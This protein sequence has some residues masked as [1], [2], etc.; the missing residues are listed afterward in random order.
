VNHLG[1]EGGKAIAEAM[2]VNSSIQFLD[3]RGKL[4]FVFALPS[5]TY[6][7]KQQT[8]LMIKVKSSK[9]SCRRNLHLLSSNFERFTRN[10]K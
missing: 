7:I 4:N 1:T 5:Q 6:Q 8:T 2:K 3:L 10:E 9:L